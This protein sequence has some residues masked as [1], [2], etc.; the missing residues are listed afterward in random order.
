MSALSHLHRPRHR[1][2]DHSMIGGAVGPL[3]PRPFSV[4]QVVVGVVVA[5]AFVVAADAA[6][7]RTIV[8][9]KYVGLLWVVPIGMVAGRAIYRARVRHRL[10][11]DR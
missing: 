1:R 6:E 2:G 8:L 5:V 9:E 7:G 11:H 4:L 10:G 3:L